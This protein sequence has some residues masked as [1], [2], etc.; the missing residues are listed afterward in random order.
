MKNIRTI[1]LATLTATLIACGGGT[2]TDQDQADLPKSE[3]TPKTEMTIEEAKEARLVVPADAN[4]FFVNINDGDTL[5]SPLHI[6]MGVSGMEV[7][8]AGDII[9]GT[10]HHHILIDNTDGFLETGTVVPMDSLNLHYGKGQTE[11][12]IELTSGEH[13]LSLQFANGFHESYGEQMS[14]TISIYVQ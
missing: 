6:E 14:S 11:T 4:V 3:D 2:G 10:G 7:E 5:S 12:D 8:P 9:N 13:K 1:G